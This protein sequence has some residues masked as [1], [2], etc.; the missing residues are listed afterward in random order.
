MS[1]VEPALLRTLHRMLRQKSDLVDQLRRCPK[2]IAGAQEREKKYSDQ[3]D[4][5]VGQQKETKIKADQKQLELKER[6]AKIEKMGNQLNEAANNK[7]YSTLQDQ[8]KA[9]EAANDVLSD[10]IL[11]LLEQADKLFQDLQQAKEVLE[12]A[13]KETASVS[14]TVSDKQKRL[15]SDL[16][17]V[18]SELEERQ[19]SLPPDVYKEYMRFV[20]DKGENTLGM[21]EDNTCCNCYQTTTSHMRTQ[22]ALSKIVYCKSC[23]ALLYAADV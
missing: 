21:V 7:E 3:V 12:K 10:E 13:K 20:V 9:T 2:Q 18:E 15:K 14:Q 22:L 16:Q 1:T 11:E 4:A 5:I 6:E 8:I 23:G 17:R 19:K